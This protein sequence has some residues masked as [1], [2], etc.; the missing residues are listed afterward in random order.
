MMCEM[1]ALVAGL[2]WCTQNSNVHE[3]AEIGMNFSIYYHVVSVGRIL[4]LCVI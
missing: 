1:I 3:I 4:V 2:V